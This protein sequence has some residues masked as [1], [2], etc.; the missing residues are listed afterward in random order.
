MLAQAAQELTF[1]HIG[2]AAAVMGFFL[3]MAVNIALMWNMSKTQKREVKFEQEFASRAEF[4]RLSETM[5]RNKTEAELGR[6]KIYEKID[7][8]RVELSEKIDGSEGRIIAT[9]KNT[10]AI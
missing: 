6:G 4:E 2:A 5:E 8:V 1:T 3:T 10:G 7:T 9:L